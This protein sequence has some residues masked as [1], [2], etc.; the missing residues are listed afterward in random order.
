MGIEETPTRREK[1]LR[2]LLEATSDWV[3]EMD[4]NA[5]YTYASSL[6]RNHL[7]WSAEEILG[8][9]PLDFVAPEERQRVGAL[10]ASLLA[11]RQPFSGLEVSCL[12]KDRA[13]AVLEIGGHPIFDS[14]GNF[15]GYHGTGRNITRSRQ[16]EETL[17]QSEAKYRSLLAN[18]PDAVWT[19]D[20]EF[21]FVFISPNIERIS[22]F[23]LDEIK[24]RGVGI[25]LD[26]LHP[27]DVA[28]VRGA[29]E[30]L[31]ARGEPYD[32]QCRVRQKNGDWIWVHDRAISTYEKDGMRYADGL[33]SDITGRRHAEEALR[34]TEEQYRL[35][36]EGIGDAVF[37][38]SFGEDSS[39]GVFLQVNDAACE[40][41]GYSREELSR[42]SPREIDDPEA[43]GRLGPVL[44]RLS[45]EKQVLFE[46][47]QIAK[48]GRRIPVEIHASL[49]QFQGQ[50]AVLAIVRDLS[51]RRRAEEV[52][53][54][55]E[56]KY[57]RLVV[58]IPDVVWTVDASDRITFISPN[59]EQL[60]GLTPE[61]LCREGPRAW[62][63]RV[64]PDDLTHV[65]EA[66]RSLFL[67]TASYNLEHR[68][69]GKDGDWRWV[70]TRSI[71][72]YEQDG[73]RC[74]LGLVTDITERQRVEQELRAAKE[75]AE[76]ANRAK[77][78]FL[79]NMSHEIR[80]PMNGILGMTEIALDT[81]LTPEQR[82]CLEMVKMSADALLTVINDILDF[83]KIEAG[84]LDLESIDF[85]LRDA[86]DQTV[87]SLALRAAQKGLDLNCRIQPGIPELVTGDPGRLRQ[88]LLNLATNAIKFTEKGAVTVQVERESQ[89][90]DGVWLRFSV[91]DTGIG[92]PADKQTAIFSAFSQADSSTTR[93]YGG[94]GLGLTISQRLAEM[95]G[96]CLS[97]ESI[98]G[99]GSTFHFR[100]RLGYG[101]APPPGSMARPVN[102]EGVPVLVVDDDFANRRILG[103]TLAG[104]HMQPTLADSAQSALL[105]LEQA[106]EAGHPFPLLLLDAHMPETD[107]F[108]LV[109]RIR[110]VRTWRGEASC[111]LLRL[112]SGETLPAAG[113]WAWP[114][115]SPSRW[116]GPNCSTPCCKFW[117][118]DPRR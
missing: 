71:G 72:A 2:A 81:D 55:S 83:S 70:Q 25:F 101:T 86:L 54:Q 78:Q 42:L 91:V 111:C 34:Q 105:C 22:G 96:G 5:R 99:Q 66:F 68:L 51:D 49:I 118:S 38:T 43:F 76:A 56:E 64:H 103:E 82:E 48:D 114:P 115:I 59:I 57:R 93:R 53:R 89:D 95:M 79:A 46:T 106:V 60:I 17:R 58:N 15:A 16:T 63:E 73:L 45:T 20:A 117:A 39:P 74:V 52:L 62:F 109:E 87:K 8:W 28:R 90:S 61:Q 112:A 44:D 40:R 41:L 94:T 19:I 32:V 97:V 13:K 30:A 104:W 50:P 37:V 47:T 9:H 6:V 3:W 23:T 67:D 98:V 33:L 18:I 84:K 116:L 1:Q 85:N 10:V 69:R 102:L 12:T 35:L 26:C 21:R 65:T 4:A 100:V 27:D 36:F 110:D 31:F 88:I 77:S 14:A 107:G 7:G 113:N 11:S 24:Q 29:F 80:T 75:A 92:I 108:T